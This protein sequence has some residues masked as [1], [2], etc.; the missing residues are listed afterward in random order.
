MKDM[1][2]VK[3]LDFFSSAEDPAELLSPPDFDRLL[4]LVPV[5]FL[6]P[7]RSPTDFVEDLSDP[8]SEE[9][10]D[11]LEPL[12]EEDEEPLDEE[13]DPEDEEEPSSP[14]PSSSDE[15]PPPDAEDADLDCLPPPVGGRFGG[16]LI[17][18]SISIIIRHS[19]N[20][21]TFSNNSSQFYGEVH[22]SHKIK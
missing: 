5:A 22:P 2:F 8:E 4:C 13:P 17:H 19:N 20:R 1:D 12:D 9:E 6:L 11:P 16:I 18:Y 3:Y 14:E 15:D 10:P 21:F 7:E